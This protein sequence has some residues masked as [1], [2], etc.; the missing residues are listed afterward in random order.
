MSGGGNQRGSP[1]VSWAYSAKF[2]CTS[3]ESHW[4]PSSGSMQKP[5]E[6]GHD[7]SQIAYY[8]INKGG[9]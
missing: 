4:E 9:L 3:P 7:T 5:I 2:R 1:F 8:S 6:V